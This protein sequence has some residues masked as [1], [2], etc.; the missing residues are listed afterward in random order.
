MAAL[1]SQCE[2]PPEGIMTL[3]KAAK[4]LPMTA[5]L[6]CAAIGLS[7]C[8]DF[9]QS[10]AINRDGSGQYQFAIA[11]RGV[12]GD[13]LK[14]GKSDIH[15]GHL[16]NAHTRTSIVDGKVTRTS[17]ADFKQLSDLNL[18]NESM[19]I[20]VRGHD[21]FGLGQTHAIFRRIFLIDNARRARQ[22]DDN[23]NAGAAVVASIFGDHVYVF[24][25]HLPGS[26]DWIAPV[27]AG[28][29]EVKPEVSGDDSHG[30]TIT[31]RMPLA[32]MIE[33]KAMRFSVGFSA[34]GALSDS[35]TRRD[36]D[37]DAM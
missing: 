37:H 29:V 25:V 21:L 5:A 35:E 18:S 27:W 2:R 30:Y 36:D 24:S 10:V 31:W 32:S 28:D 14:D 26:I 11:A 4:S 1:C 19:A 13:A 23:G 6:L 33:T 22:R 3:S 12:V 15:I 17:S 8:F 7:G 34:Y 20:K 16:D 9:S